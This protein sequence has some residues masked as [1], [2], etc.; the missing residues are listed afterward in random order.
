MRIASTRRR[1]GVWPGW[2][3][4]STRSWCTTPPSSSTTGTLDRPY[5][6]DDEPAPQSVYGMTKLVG[7]RF[8]QRAER[9]YVLRLSSLYG[10][11]TRRTTVDWILRQAQAGQRVTAFADRTVSPSYVPDVVEATLE[12]VAN[13]APFGLYN[14]GSVDSCTW[15]DW[16]SGF[17]PPAAGPTSCSACPSWRT[18]T[19][20]FGRRTARCRAPSCAAR[21]SWHRGGGATRFPITCFAWASAAASERRLGP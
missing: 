2:P 12:L 10:G 16:R 3:R 11:H 21:L 4:N 7:E 8:A 15:A 6:E 1:S 17:L 5:T 20:R 9:S 19:G 13:A 18:Q 14:C